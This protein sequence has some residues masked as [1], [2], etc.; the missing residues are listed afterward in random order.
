MSLFDY[1]FADISNFFSLTRTIPQSARRQLPLHKG[2]GLAVP[3]I[4]KVPMKYLLV[5]A[6][7]AF[8]FCNKEMLL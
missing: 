5:F 3:I 4:Q 6:Y 1:F 2:A 7:G 8:N